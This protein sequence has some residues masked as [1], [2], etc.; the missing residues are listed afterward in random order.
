MRAR[1]P[2]CFALDADA[3]SRQRPV[4]RLPDRLDT[5]IYSRRRPASNQGTSMEAEASAG[6]QYFFNVD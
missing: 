3:S 4:A 6:H 2:A 5:R 1:R